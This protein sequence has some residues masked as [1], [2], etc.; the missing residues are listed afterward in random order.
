MKKIFR[1][2]FLPVM[3][4]IVFPVVSSG[5]DFSNGCFW[6]GE[7][8]IS[9]NVT[10]QIGGQVTSPQP[11]GS[12]SNPFPIS[13]L[14]WPL[15]VT[16][17]TL[18]A[19]I[20]V[21][22]NTE[23]GAEFSKNVTSYSGKMQDS[24]YDYDTAGNASL[25]T[26]SQN[27]ADVQTIT[28]DI[29]LRYWM[30]ATTMD[31]GAEVASNYTA[32]MGIGGGELYQKFNW[33]ASNLNQTDIDQGGVVETQSGLIGTYSAVTSMPYLEVLG[34]IEK[35]N[36][37]SL[38]LRFGY[39]P[40]ASVNDWDD[41]LLRQISATSSLYGSAYKVSFQGTYDFAP[42]WFLSGKYDLVYFDLTGTESD[43]VYGNADVANGNNQG[44]SWT[45]QHETSSTNYMMA[46]SIGRRF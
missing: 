42:N 6:I 3:M 2:L 13:K 20:P 24:D 23:I 5:A 40:F 41:H 15:N 44:D 11:G 43:L 38:L 31:F 9:G 30:T 25:G 7:G 35:P 22:A 1:I 33:T 37:M 28:A 46:L 19:L 29:D 45:I 12:S 4:G 39:S 16:V 17:L 27:D 8:L 26:Y 36:V 10:Y 34:K 18:G 32:R 14:Q 21:A